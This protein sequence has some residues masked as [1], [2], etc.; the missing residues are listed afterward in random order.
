MHSRLNQKF[1]PLM[2]KSFEFSLFVKKSK[3]D[4]KSTAKLIATNNTSGDRGS[5]IKL[6]VPNPFTRK[7]N[8]IRKAMLSPTANRIV[9]VI[10]DR[11]IR[12]ILRRTKPGTNT[13][14]MK[15][16]T[17]RIKIM[18]RRNET[19]WTTCI[20]NMYVKNLGRL[21]SSFIKG[22]LPDI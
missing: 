7:P 18:S 5:D 3:R 20:M 2:F 12:N 14:N 15:P 9:S 4:I 6:I 16:E 8:S 1:N 21:K 22:F 17:W 11:F 19:I 10:L 13:K